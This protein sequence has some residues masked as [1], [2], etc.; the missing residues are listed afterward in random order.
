M[1]SNMEKLTN[2]A[3]LAELLGKSDQTIINW[4]TKDKY[5]LKSKYMLRVGGVW[6]IDSVGYAGLMCEVR[7]ETREFN[8]IKP[9]ATEVTK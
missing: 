7:K 2:I 6:M 5:N 4:I 1:E 8:A 9:V 3:G